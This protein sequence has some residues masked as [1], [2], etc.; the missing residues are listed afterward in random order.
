MLERG[1]H[2]KISKL[3]LPLVSSIFIL[4][5]CGGGGGGSSGGSGNT[6]NAV[7]AGIWQGT[8]SSGFTVDLI[9][10][11]N[12]SFATIFGNSL[13]N[14]GLSVVGFDIG[15]GS[16]SGSTFTASGMS[17]FTSAGYVASGNITATVTNNSSII[18]SATYS[19][20]TTST[21]NLVPLTGISYSIPASLTAIAGSWSGTLLGGGTTNVT[22]NSTTGAIA[23][24]TSGGCS[25][26][27]TITPSTV[28][29]YTTSI[30]IGA[31][32]CVNPNTTVS[33]IGVA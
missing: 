20:G 15:S 26:T 4:C 27:G 10:L 6:A 11:P 9:V 3:V 13:V 17:E 16:I 33:G 5:S 30:I 25:F 32:P 24:L 7:A 2:M 22:I 12:N 8:S 29:A 18:G 19:T 14:G 23:G 21:F 1:I 31:S 28:N